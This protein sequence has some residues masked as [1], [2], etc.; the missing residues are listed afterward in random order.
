M[1]ATERRTAVGP[2]KSR[3]F[4]LKALPVCTCGQSLH[5]KGMV[6]ALQSDKNCRPGP[7]RGLIKSCV[8]T[9]RLDCHCCGRSWDAR[10]LCVDRYARTSHRAVPTDCWPIRWNERAEDALSAILED[11]KREERGEAPRPRFA[12]E[13]P[14]AM[15]REDAERARRN[16]AAIRARMGWA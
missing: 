16:I 9:I 3:W 13:T 15:T 1:T 4:E 5:R 6:R 8:S 2:E 14:K 10:F 12:P 11:R 7:G